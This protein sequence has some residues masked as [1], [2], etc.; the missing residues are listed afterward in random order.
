MKKGIGKLAAIT[1]FLLA[2]GLTA[3]DRNAGTSGAPTTVN[4]ID[5]RI[6]DYEKVASEYVRVA[7]KLKNGDVSI[8]FKY[9]QLDAQTK[10]ESARLQEEAPKMTP[11]QAQRV[12]DIAAKTAPYLQP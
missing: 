5:A 9:I 4:P 3:C 12:A 11:Q 1:L 10:T 6:D 7:K 8:T 2:G